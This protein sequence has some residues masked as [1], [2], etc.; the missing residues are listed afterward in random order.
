MILQRSGI[1]AWITD[2]EG[3]RLKE[4]QVEETADGILQCWVPSVEGANFKIQWEVIGNPRPGFDLCAYPHLDGVKFTGSVL[5]TK[6]ITRGDIG[7][8]SKE[9]IGISTARLYEFGKRELTDK[10]TGIKLDSLMA[11][12]LNTIQVDFVWGRGGGSKSKKQ[13]EEH[14][15]IGPI[16]EKTAKKGHTGA[17][18]LGRTV[19][20]SKA[21]RC[22]FH[23]SRNIKQDTFIFCYAPE[24]KHDIFEHVDDILPASL[25]TID[26]LRAREIIPTTPEPVSQHSRSTQ[27][28]ARNNAARPVDVDELETDDDEIQFI[29]HLPRQ[30]RYPMLFDKYGLSAW[31]TNSEG[32][33]LPEYQVQETSDDTIQCWI[34]STN[35]TNFKIEWKILKNPHPKLDIRTT[36]YLD[37]VRLRG[38][39]WGKSAFGKHDRQ[40]IG[41][42]TAQLYEFGER[43]LTDNDNYLKPD[44]S[45][46]ESMNTIKLTLHWGQ[47]SKS[48]PTRSFCKPQ[49]LAPVH[50]KAAKKGHSGAAKL[51]KTVVFDSTAEGSVTFE[52]SKSIK[53]LNFVFCYAP[54]DWLRAREIIPHSPEPDS[55]DNQ[56]T[57]KRERSATPEI[58]DIDELETDDDEIQIIKHM[59]PA[60]VA[61]KR[62]RTTG[63]KDNVR[64]KDEDN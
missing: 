17:A 16:H 52:P 24:G 31:I 64:P 33:E 23:P 49:E 29:K 59:I 46:L 51:G 56:S 21:T 8:L 44:Q 40:S 53:P 1:S 62:Q 55:Q 19:S 4:Y 18:K 35:G 58:I 42:S 37:G 57:L 60:P 27:K 2:S 11:K 63:E 45:I 38:T 36:P 41:H 25:D 14:E 61:N 54:E 32:D 43:V 50:E 28:R 5:Y 39:A 10:D 12:R 20:I 26:W 6:N 15:E 30:H 9:S 34:P 3:D 48:R 22:T 13:F 47:Q 7:Q